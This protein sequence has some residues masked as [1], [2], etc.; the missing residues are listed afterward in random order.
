MAKLV[1]IGENLKGRV[2]ELV[3]DQTTVGRGE[4]NTL[5]IHDESI[6]TQHCEILVYG[7][8][9]IVRDLGSTNG[10][11][12]DGLRLHDQQCQVK[13]GQIVQFG[14][15]PARLEIEEPCSTDRASDVTA[16][17][18]LSRLMRDQQKEKKRPK[19]TEPSMTLEA[20]A[21]PGSL[22]DTVRLFRP[23]Q[24]EPTMAPLVQA[25]VDFGKGA[26]AKGVV[27]L[28]IGLALGLVILLWLM[29]GKK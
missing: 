15:V 3:V 24:P 22:D 13:A 5:V 10:T 20:G 2:Y 19:P 11:F 9:V 18:E 29:V 27:V 6:S 23:F 14:S 7:P 25:K 4:P 1:F 12:V 28:V 16:V 26:P 17:Y 21:K 8:E